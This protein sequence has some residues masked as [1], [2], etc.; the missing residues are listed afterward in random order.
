VE[1]ATKVEE[2]LQRQ[3]VV[4]SPAVQPKKTQQQ[5]A[6]SKPAQ[7]QKRRGDHP[8]RAGQG[9]R[10]RC[11]SCGS[12]DHKVADCTQ[13]AET[14]ECYHYRERGYLRPNC[15]KLQWMAMAIVQPA[16]QQEAQVQQGVQQNVQQCTYCSS[17]TG[18]HYA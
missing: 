17:T 11:F 5:V 3:V 14:R 12:L 8:F 16:V 10:V 7:G 2:D 9:G 1:T 6:P 15:P 4:V 13:R 18:L